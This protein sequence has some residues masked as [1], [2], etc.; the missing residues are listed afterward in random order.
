MSRGFYALTSGM[1]T[2]QRKIDV[3][4]NNIAN[5]NTPGYKKEQ[6]VTSNFGKMLISKYKSDGITED[7]EIIG[8]ISAI[9]VVDENNTIHS[10]GSL[11]QTDRNLDFAIKGSGFFL[12][13]GNGN[14]I[15]TR[16]GSFNLD[17]EGYLILND[18]GRVQ[19]EYGDIYIGTDNFEF[20]SDGTISLDGTPIEKIQIYDFDDYNTLTKNKDGTYSSASQSIIVENPTLQ[21]GTI[22]K[23]NV[24]ITEEMADIIASQRALQSCSQAIKIYDIALEK[25]VNEIGKI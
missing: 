19:G 15:Y 3:I 25:A 7:A 14:Q 6:A 9:R 24:N 21:T 11:E 5:I 12:I 8:S 20:N 23:S 18:V 22:E 17:S 16:D 1:L 13:N 4:S 10:Q 2:Q